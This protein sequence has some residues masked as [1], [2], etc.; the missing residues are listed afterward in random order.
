MKDFQSYLAP[1]LGIGVLIA[2]DISFCSINYPAFKTYN[3]LI[4]SVY[5]LL[6]FMAVWSLLMTMCRDP[7]YVK[8]SA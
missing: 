1:V 4:I 8:I 2:C 6:A 3:L 7:G 5:N